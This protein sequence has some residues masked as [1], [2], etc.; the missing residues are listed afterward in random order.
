MK[1]EKIPKSFGAL[2]CFIF[3]LLLENIL[4]FLSVNAYHEHLLL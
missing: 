3:A 1:P 4:E 2:K